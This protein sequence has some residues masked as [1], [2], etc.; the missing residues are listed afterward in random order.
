MGNLAT[1]LKDAAR[2]YPQ[3][4]AV[5]L[6][7][8]VLGY[9]DLD[10][11]SARVAGALLAHGVRPGERV[12]LALAEPD[13]PA[14]AVLYY[15][16][17][18]TGAVVAVADP[19]LGGQGAR[20]CFEAPGTRIVFAT[21]GF[22]VPPA[23]EPDAAWVPVG[24]GLLDQLAHWPQHHEIVYR[25]DEAVAVAYYGPGTADRL[26]GAELTHG[27]MRAH[28]FAAAT[29]PP[30]LEPDDLV[31]CRL[32]LCHPAGQTWG[33]NAAVLAGACLAVAP[34]AATGCTP[35]RPR[36]RRGATGAHRLTPGH[37]GPNPALGRRP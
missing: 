10:E 3:R 21:A 8:S 11:L 22:P 5:I 6:R 32:P 9:A 18:R 37:R 27:E 16:A 13:A 28:A 36:L 24:P 4:P 23:S 2:Q 33:L 25:P 20:R 19:R 12:G 26:H 7:G 29:E 35:R 15:G 30:V 1:N 34:D 17:L 14:F 31:L